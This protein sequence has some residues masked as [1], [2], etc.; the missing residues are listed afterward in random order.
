MIESIAVITSD[1][2]DLLEVLQKMSVKLKVLK[3]GEVEKSDLNEFDSFV[4]IGGVDKEPLLLKPK[5]RILIEEQLYKGKRIFSEYCGSIGNV[6]FDKPQHTRFEQLV[7][8]DQKIEVPGFDQGDL[9]DDQYGL[10]IRPHDIS[11]V[12]DVPILQYTK[13][14][15]HDSVEWSEDLLADVSDRAL[16]FDQPKTYSYVPFSY[17]TFIKIVLAQGKESIN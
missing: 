15:A 9:I 14:H 3:P 13:K 10:R 5:E 6:Y 4:I 17:V 7:Y 11:C 8:C 2:S 12:H 16:W 1:E